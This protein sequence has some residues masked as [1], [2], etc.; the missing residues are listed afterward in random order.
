MGLAGAI[1]KAVVGWYPFAGR[2]LAGWPARI[3][4]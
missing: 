4:V 3:S 1:C 2:H